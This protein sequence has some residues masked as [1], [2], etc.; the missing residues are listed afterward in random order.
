[1]FEREGLLQNAVAVGKQLREGAVE[2]GL[3]VQGH[4]LL[5]GL[6]VGRPAAQV[7]KALFGQRILTGTAS[8]PEVLRL[9][10]PLNFSHDEAAL[11]L[12]G[13]RTVLA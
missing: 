7:Q 13:L 9:L 8:D 3:G 2:L 5:L 12:Q 11:V 4:G 1:M 10:P 6:R